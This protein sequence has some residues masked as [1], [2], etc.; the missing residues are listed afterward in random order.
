M[1][2]FVQNNIYSY[3]YELYL[4]FLFLLYVLKIYIDLHIII[5]FCT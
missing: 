2:I 1:H 5:S 3:I 4:V